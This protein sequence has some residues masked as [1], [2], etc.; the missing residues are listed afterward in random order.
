MC[1]TAA[2][3][4]HQTLLAWRGFQLAA[5]ATVSSLCQSLILHSS[6]VLVVYQKR[7]WRR[8]EMQL[9][10]AEEWEKCITHHLWEETWQGTGS[11]AGRRPSTSTGAG[12]ALNLWCGFFH[13]WSCCCIQILFIVAL[14]LFFCFFLYLQF[15]N[16]CLMSGFFHSQKI[17]QQL[18]C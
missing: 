17:H 18:F 2:P 8:L 1:L 12:A 11:R 9:T 4:L 10:C 14:M 15:C 5:A 3:Q 6:R 7:G 16:V 13:C